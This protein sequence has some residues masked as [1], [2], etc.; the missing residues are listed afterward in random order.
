MDLYVYTMLFIRKLPNIYETLY[1]LVHPFRFFFLSF[2]LSLLLLFIVVAGVI[3]LLSSS[4]YLLPYYMRFGIRTPKVYIHNHVIILWA[5]DVNQRIHYHERH[6]DYSM[7]NIGFWRRCKWLFFFFSLFPC[8]K[9]WCVY[10][11]FCCWGFWHLTFGVISISKCIHTEERS[12][13]QMSENMYIDDMFVS[14]AATSANVDFFYPFFL[15]FAHCISIYD[16]GLFLIM[17]CDLI[18][19][20]NNQPPKK[21]TT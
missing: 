3:H 21:H 2:F 14:A 15:V 17:L 9:W 7:L 8:H 4:T 10:K 1:S 19:T 12:H 6:I 16:F 20:F 18:I 13:C 11:C 5:N